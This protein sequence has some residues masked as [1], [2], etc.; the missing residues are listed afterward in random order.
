MWFSWLSSPAK[1]LLHLLQMDENCVLAALDALG[2]M[3]QGSQLIPSGVPKKM[4]DEKNPT[5][6]LA[7]TR[8]Q[9]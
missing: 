6:F 3:G 7:M 1:A 5:D 9:Q 2:K 4:A 8:G